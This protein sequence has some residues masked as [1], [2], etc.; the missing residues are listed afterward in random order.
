MLSTTNVTVECKVQ[1]HV[2][3]TLQLQVESHALAVSVQVEMARLSF[4]LVDLRVRLID[5]SRGIDPDD[6]RAEVGQHFGTVWTGDS[7]G[8]F[9]NTYAV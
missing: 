6:F 1:Q 7:V 3:A 4:D 5:G 8:Q 9:Q 2:S